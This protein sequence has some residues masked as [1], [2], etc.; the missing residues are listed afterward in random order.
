MPA[1]ADALTNSGISG[2]RW[3]SRPNIEWI[4][5]LT[6]ARDCMDHWISSLRS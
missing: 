1:I 3:D 5:K 2:L 4:A 6:D